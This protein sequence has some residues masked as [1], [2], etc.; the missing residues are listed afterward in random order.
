MHRAVHYLY[1]HNKFHLPGSNYSLVIGIKLKAKES[2]CNAEM[3]N[4]HNHRCGNLKC[5]PFYILQDHYMN[6][7]LIV[8]Q[9]QLQYTV[10]V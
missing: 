1:G 9:D 7:N 8:F 6:R 3:S 5:M 4:L 10:S 2:V